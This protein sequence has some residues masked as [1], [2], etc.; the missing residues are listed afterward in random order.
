MLLHS[1]LPGTQPAIRRHVGRS[2][3][4]RHG[5]LHTCH[6]TRRPSGL[7]S[8]LAEV[9]SSSR[10]APPLWLRSG[11]VLAPSS[12]ADSSPTLPPVASFTATVW[13]FGRSAFA[14]AVKAR[15]P[16]TRTTGTPWWP[17]RKALI[18]VSPTSVPFTRTAATVPLYV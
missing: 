17:A 3:S 2:G 14:S 1:H 12:D 4:S 6:G 10:L 15:S 11:S 7:G 13:T 16:V 5:R 18:P 9:R 8:S